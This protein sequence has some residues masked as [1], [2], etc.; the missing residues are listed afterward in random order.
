MRW[1]HKQLHLD[2]DITKPSVNTLLGDAFIIK[3]YIVWHSFWAQNFSALE[4]EREPLKSTQTRHYKSSKHLIEYNKSGGNIYC[5]CCSEP[6][7]LKVS[8]TEA[9]Q[10]GTQAF[11]LKHMDYNA[12]RL[13]WE[14]T[15]RNT[16]LS[17]CASILIVI[18][19]II[20]RQSTTFHTIVE[21]SSEICL[22]LKRENQRYEIPNIL[23]L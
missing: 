10:N 11:F 22:S 2:K 3:L 9:F 14:V 8:A 23:K 18:I 15:L 21:L 5:Y 16:S 13:V 4:R 1:G 6:L 12:M 17:M 20:W 7:G 19:I